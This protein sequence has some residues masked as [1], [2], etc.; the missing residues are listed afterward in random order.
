M[1]VMD[2]EILPALLGYI[3]G[4]LCRFNLAGW[5]IILFYGRDYP[6]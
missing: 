1:T 2:A 6:E 4:Y 3:D 5:L